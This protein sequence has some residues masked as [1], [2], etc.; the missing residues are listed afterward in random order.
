MLPTYMTPPDEEED[1]GFFFESGFRYVTPRGNDIDVG[2]RDG[3]TDTGSFLDGD[4]DYVVT[5]RAEG[6]EFDGVFSGIYK[7][8]YKF[9]D[10]STISGSFWDLKAGESIRL[11]A[12]SGGTVWNIYGNPNSIPVADSI[13]VRLKLHLKQFDFNYTRPI[14]HTKKFKL[15]GL[16]G[17]RYAEIDNNLQVTANGSFVG[18]GSFETNDTSISDINTRMFGAKFGLLQEYNFCKRFSLYLNSTT[19]LLLGFTEEEMFEEATG[20]GFFGPTGSFVSSRY[21][22]VHPVYEVD[23]GFKY[24]ILPDMFLKAGYHFGYWTDVITRK[25]SVDDVKLSGS[26]EEKQSLTL[27]GLSVYLGYTF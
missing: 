18:E 3:N 22:E 21:E 6:A 25:R 5:G 8:G 11:A 24:N 12:P 27:D 14:L 19:S 23:A 4:T 2:I 1:T 15:D 9:N 26:V 17:L 16:V 7:L 20:G 13:T 10:G